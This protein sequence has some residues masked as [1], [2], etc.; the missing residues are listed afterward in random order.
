M[1]IDTKINKLT[2]F[3][4]SKCDEINKETSKRNRKLHFKHI[5]YFISKLITNNSSYALT[6]SELKNDNIINVSSQ[7]I[8]KKRNNIDSKY[9]LSFMNDFNKFIYDDELIPKADMFGID[10][11]TVSIDKKFVKE[12]FKLTKN[13]N[14]CKGYLSCIYDVKNKI[15]LGYCIDKSLDER[16]SFIDNLLHLVP[17][18]ATLLF[19]RGYYS[20]HLID[21]LEKRNIKYVIRMKKNNNYIKQL[22][23]IGKDQ[24]IN[25]I[26]GQYLSRI[27]MYKIDKEKYYLCSN[28]FNVHIDDFSNL[29]HK[30]WAIEEHYKTLKCSMKLDNINCT[31]LNLLKQEIYMHLFINMK[32]RYLELISIACKLNK[33]KLNENKYTINYKNT[34]NVTTN[35]ILPSILFDTHNNNNIKLYLTTIVN[36]FVTNNKIIGRHFVRKRIKPVSLWYYTGLSRK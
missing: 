35:K 11:S 20:I 29:Y 3:I 13:G 7:A 27:I 10:G 2:S 5:F 21:C 24:Y 1:I 28:I 18:N 23:V 22:N 14:Y 33:K 12:G 30:R 32:G 8:R 36:E 4:N 34:L 31:N 25:Y 19:D 26:N 17:N 15:P 16:K 6:N 9:F